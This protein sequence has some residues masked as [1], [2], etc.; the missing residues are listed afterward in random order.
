MKNLQDGLGT[1]NISE[2]ALKEIYG[3]YKAKDLTEE[4]IKKCKMTERDIFQ[5]YDNLSESELNTKKPPKNF[6]LKM[7][8]WLL[9]L[10]A[11]EVQKK[12]VKEK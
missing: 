12:Y 9:F 3:I 10:N 2:L 1:Q 7:T 11:A 4:Q 6:M 5:K 8:L